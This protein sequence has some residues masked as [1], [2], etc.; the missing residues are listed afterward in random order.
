VA[1]SS[2]QWQAGATPLQQ[3]NDSIIAG[4]QGQAAIAAN[5][6]GTG[7]FAAWTDP[8]AGTTVE[9]RLM[10]AGGEPQ[11]SQFTVNTGLAGA[12]GLASVAGLADGRYITVFKDT[13]NDPAGDIHGRI[14]NADGSPAGNDFVVTNSAFADSE[15]HVVGLDDGGYVVT[16]TRG[17]GGNDLDVRASIYNS[18]GTVRDALINV[19]LSSLT[20][21]R[22][23][24]V[25]A[26]AGGGF[27]VV[28]DQSPT[29]GGSTE[30]RFTRFDANGQPL[31][32]ADG[33]IFDQ[34]GSINQDAHVVGLADGGFAIAYTDNG[35]G[36]SGTEISTVVFNANGTLRSSFLEP[37]GLANGGKTFDNQQTPSL[38][39]LSNGGFAVS[40][41]D[42]DT[43]SEYL[44]AYD[45]Q[46]NAL[47]PNKIVL[48]NSQDA[49]I[50]GL[51]HG[52]VAMLSDS[53]IP[54]GDGNSIRSKIYQLVHVLTG[55]ASNEVI[56]A[57]ESGIRETI[58][59]AG[60]DDTVT[61]SHDLAS[62]QVTDFGKY[63]DVVRDGA[64][65]RLSNVEHLQFGDGTIDVNDGN[66]LFDTVYYMTHNPDVFH[67]HVNALAHF[68]ASGWHEGRDPN[69]FFSVNG[70]LATN[71]DVKA[72]GMNPLDQY[73]QSGWQQ[74]RDPGANFDTK[75]YL[76]HNP[77]V[78]A[79]GVDPLA[80]Y[81]QY[82]ITEGRQ[83]Y[84]AIGT[85]VT[86]FDAEYYLLHNPD[87]A[88]SGMDPLQH[89][90]QF[91]WHEGRNPNAWFD[92]KGYLAHYG[93]VA[94]ANVNPLQHYE[95]DG[96]Q[97]GRDPSAGFDTLGYLA[98]NP[99][100]AAAHVNPL[101]HFIN[102]GIYEGRV[103]INDGLFH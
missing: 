23:S 86:G 95:Q 55:D 88:A 41:N 62:Y 72:S 40:W 89:F 47:G 56:Q 48:G 58:D 74:G 13:G 33:V 53:L 3:T 91:G 98:A 43:H 16:W 68:D 66:P 22:H 97:E 94:A 8:M 24:S 35:W 49:E 71:P 79:A 25:A 46:G 83:A 51:A 30:V 14:F 9:G 4:A 69:A 64:T 15:P 75:L 10:L 39:A 57:L 96:W 2:Y 34:A 99:D 87:V 37:N 1:T 76:L 7:F 31:D 80:H 45:A 60:G 21:E 90:N 32:P 42:A 36:Q 63:I 73:D 27:V 44:Q 38:A 20:A 81:L 67:A 84:Q 65:T 92:T 103:A 59:G 102:S 5:A 70:Y 18:D 52:T 54:D 85:A 82:G 61:F 29:G 17:F 93:D 101:D 6:S 50:A 78:A 28:W 100:V 19:T 26:L 11:G 12:H 77:D